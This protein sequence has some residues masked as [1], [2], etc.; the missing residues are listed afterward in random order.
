VTKTRLK[1][2]KIN[3]FFQINRI[4]PSIQVSFSSRPVRIAIVI[5]TVFFSVPLM[6]CFI[7]AKIFE[8]NFDALQNNTSPLISS[9][10]FSWSYAQIVFITLYLLI[11]LGIC[12][13]YKKINQ[14]LCQSFHL[15][16]LKNDIQKTLNCLSQL[17]LR[18]FQIVSLTNKIFATPI[19]VSF[20]FYTSSG[21][22]SLYELFSIYSVPNVTLQQIGFCFIVSSWFP[23][24][25]C[26]MILE[27]WCCSVT[28]SEGN[29]TSKILRN[30]LCNE[31]DENVQKHL[32]MFLMQIS[33]SRP[34]FSCGLFEFCWEL[35]GIVS[36]T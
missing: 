6:I 8:L 20:G 17:H 1:N 12:E 24:A 19:M 11:V 10:I 33:H 2:T 30:K 32:K 7:I 27:I 4:S 25:V 5:A 34:V 35:L 22:F 36:M 14:I 23:N 18:A 15:E 16:N 29:R 26:I 31:K 28:V 13:R 9:F 21:V 3:Y